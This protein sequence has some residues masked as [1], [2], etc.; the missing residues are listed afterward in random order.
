MGDKYHDYGCQKKINKFIL[1]YVISI[2]AIK[3]SDD[4]RCCGGLLH[5][6]WKLMQSC[7]RV[8]DME[9]F[10]QFSVEIIHSLRHAPIQIAIVI[11]DGIIV[12]PSLSV[13]PVSCN[14]Y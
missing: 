8:G 13:Q 7:A 12:C 2:P 9:I 10:G 11:W 4:T 1:F 5:M 6:L 3:R 14:S